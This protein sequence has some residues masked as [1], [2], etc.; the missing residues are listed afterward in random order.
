[1]GFLDRFKRAKLEVPGLGALQRRGGVWL[2]AMPLGGF[3][4]VPLE[5]AG[6]HDGVPEA[7]VRLA[8]DLMVRY[9]SLRPS[10]QEGLYDHYKPYLEN[11]DDDGLPAID[12]AAEIWDYVA[13]AHV[14]IEPLAG[15]ETVE[16]GFDTTWDVEHTPAARFQNWQL[17]EFNGSVPGV[18]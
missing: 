4:S 3:P 2:G 8:R 16:I 17:V 18:Y 13:L 14:R 11:P 10:I 1:M 6:T 15:I 9:D 5:L 7:R 12:S